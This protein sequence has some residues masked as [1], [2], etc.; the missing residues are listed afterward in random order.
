LLTP[1]LAEAVHNELTSPARPINPEAMLRAQRTLGNRATRDLLHGGGGLPIQRKPA[2]IDQIWPVNYDGTGKLLN[3]VPP[4][5]DFRTTT[6][7]NS[8]ARDG[9]VTPT[10]QLKGGHLLKKELGGPDNDQNVVPWAIAT[11]TQFT[12]FEKDYQDAIDLDV[13]AATASSRPFDATVHAKATFEDRPDLEVSDSDLDGAGWPNGDALREDRKKKFREVAEKFSHIPTKVAVDVTG[14][15]G[16]AL[17][18]AKAGTDVAPKYVRNDAALKKPFKPQPYD[19]EISPVGVPR[20]W[21]MV[22]NTWRVNGDE[23]RK[24]LQHE[25]SHRTDWG[26]A[27]GDGGTVA[28]LKLFETRLKAHVENVNNTQIKGIYRGTT[29]VIHYLN[30]ITNQWAC[31]LPDGRLQCAWILGPGQLNTLLSIGSVK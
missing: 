15:S 29:V 14:V 25:W 19:F 8:D 30:P 27:A 5:A 20:A 9:W 12:S 23:V 6:A 18:F 16:P 2:N 13:K 24:Q 26:F 22:E 11:E 4:R 3:V 7:I 17:S 21:K 28:N 31:T 10:D 1:A